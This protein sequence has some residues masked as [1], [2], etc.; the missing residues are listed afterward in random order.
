MLREQMISFLQTAVV[1]LLLT[2]GI[3]AL[4][5]VYAVRMANALA[6]PGREAKGAVE[7]RLDILL[8]RG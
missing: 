6:N 3:T 1:V 4:A 2:N 8:G 5:A 7:R